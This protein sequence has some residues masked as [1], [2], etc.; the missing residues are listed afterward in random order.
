MKTLATRGLLS[1][2]LNAFE[3]GYVAGMIDG[4]GYIRISRWVAKKDSKPKYGPVIGIASTT[5]SV[6]IYL[7]EILGVG[8]LVTI[9]P[10]N[11]R[12]K[13]AYS[14]CIWS[15]QA[16]SVLRQIKSCLII[17]AE[18]AELFLAY[19]DDADLPSASIYGLAKSELSRRDRLVAGLKKLNERG[20]KPKRR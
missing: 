8:Q 7:R 6:L 19:F 11:K 14:L 17:K 18:Q 2:K 16:R 5:K 1:H 15:Q 10:A 13:T 3:R 12:H 20:C 4:E 9:R